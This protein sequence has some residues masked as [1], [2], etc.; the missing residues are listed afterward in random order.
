MKS[1]TKPLERPPVVRDAYSYIR[2]SSKKQADGASLE[3]QLTG[4]RKYCE[5]NNL[6]LNETLTFQDLGVSAF[7][8]DNLDHSLG[9]LLRACEDGLIP[10]GSALVVEALDRLSRQRPRVVSTFV[11]ATSS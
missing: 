4:T 8:G 10:K 3:R 11:L 9:E 5:E 7:K 2:F 6:I 1:K